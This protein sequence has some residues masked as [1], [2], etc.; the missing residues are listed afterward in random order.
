MREAF[1]QPAHAP[2]T[3]R[4]YDSLLRL[5]NHRWPLDTPQLWRRWKGWIQTMQKLF[6]CLMSSCLV[7]QHITSLILIELLKPDRQINEQNKSWFH[8]LIIENC[9][10]ERMNFWHHFFVMGNTGT[11]GSFHQQAETMDPFLQGRHLF[12]TRKTF[13]LEIQRIYNRKT[14]IHYGKRRTPPHAFKFCE[15]PFWERTATSSMCR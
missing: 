9:W 11:F 3:R 5:K 10:Y 1:D 13:R 14:P 7:T 4:Q 2:A 6:T 15:N 8:S 12:V